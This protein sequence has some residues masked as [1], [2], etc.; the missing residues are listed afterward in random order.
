[1]ERLAFP[2]APRAVANAL[3]LLEAERI[4]DL[5]SALGS[6]RFDALLALLVRNAVSAPRGCA[7]HAAAGIS[8]PA[9]PRSTT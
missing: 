1:M 2:G 7:P 5:R 9:A 8:P 3:D 4:E 6:I